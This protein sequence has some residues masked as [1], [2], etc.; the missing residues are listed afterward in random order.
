MSSVNRLKSTK[1]LS[2]LPC[3]ILSMSSITSQL[4]LYF[5]TMAQKRS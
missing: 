5:G 3:R 1:P 4:P 2:Q